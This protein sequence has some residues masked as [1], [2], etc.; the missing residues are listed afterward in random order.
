MVK[1][2]E[3]IEH[4]NQ[5]V[6]LKINIKYFFENQGN[7]S[8]AISKSFFK[9][10]LRRLGLVL[11]SVITLKKET[12]KRFGKILKRESFTL[13]ASYDQTIN[14][15]LL[16]EFLWNL[17][18]LGFFCPEGLLPI[19]PESK[20]LKKELLFNSSPNPTVS[21]II[22]VYNQIAFTYNC[23]QSLSQNLPRYIAY[24]IILID[25]NSNDQTY[26]FINSN[27]KGLIY[28]N[29]NNNRGFLYSCNRAS[30]VAKGTYLC[31]LNNDTI[32]K[33]GWLENLLETFKNDDKV[34]C[35]GSK[36]I[37]PCGLLQEAGGIIYDDGTTERYGSL[38]SPCNPEFNIPKEVDYC[39][40]ASIL[41]KKKDFDKLGGFDQRYEPAYYEDTDLCLSLK[42]ILGKK[43][44]YQPLSEIIHFEN[45][46][47]KKHSIQTQL[48]ANKMKFFKKWQ[49]T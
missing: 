13:S 20:I 33:E 47:A 36:L 11:L 17:S 10:Y 3:W 43:V 2:H 44:L 45:I 15:T 14:Y 16:K 24:E 6:C 46:S 41:I 25:D 48:T 26:E 42:R 4:Q 34:G 7:A 1:I 38:E 39:S 40:G 30:S 8:Y 12:F 19:L 9:L 49:K 27:T 32:V 28:L 35:V 29:N 37:F 21:I 5:K 18:G 23:L 22:P 31:F